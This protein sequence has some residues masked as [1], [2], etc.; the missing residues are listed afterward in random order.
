MDKY[1][2]GKICI[3]LDHHWTIFS[4]MNKTSSIYSNA[5]IQQEKKTA[6][7]SSYQ[8]KAMI[9]CRKAGF[10]IFTLAE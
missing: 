2:F 4:N 6:P 7:S 1:C 3:T 9:Y 8:I 5:R 10:S